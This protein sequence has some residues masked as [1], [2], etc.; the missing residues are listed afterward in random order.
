MASSSFW[1]SIPGFA[2][3]IAVGA[4]GSVF[5]VSQKGSIQR[6]TGAG[7]AKI[8]DVQAT[9]I[10]VGPRGELHFIDPGRGLYRFNFA[11]IDSKDPSGNGPQLLATDHT[12]VPLSVPGGAL[13]VGIGPAGTVFVVASDGA[14][15]RME[16]GAAVRLPGQASRIAVGPGEQPFVLGTDRRVYAW[17]NGAFSP[18]LDMVAPAVDLGVGATGVVW[19]AGADGRADCWDPTAGARITSL[20]LSAAAFGVGSDGLA[21]ALQQDGSICR[22]VS[23]AVSAALRETI[24][25]SYI[26]SLPQEGCDIAV[27]PEGN[28]WMVGTDSRPYELRGNDWT[29]VSGS[30]AQ[31]ITV[32]L[33]NQPYKVAGDLVW[34]REGDFWKSM[35][36]P[37]SGALDVAAGPNGSLYCAGNDRNIYRWDGSQWISVAGIQG[38]RIALGPLDVPYVLANDGRIYKLAGG[39]RILVGNQSVSARDVAVGI[40]GTIWMAGHDNN[41]YRYDPATK[42]YLLGPVQATSVAVAPNGWLL[43]VKPDNGLARQAASAILC[44]SRDFI[45]S[46]WLR[47]LGVEPDERSITDHQNH[48]LYRLQTRAQK[49]TEFFKCD[50]S[51]RRCGADGRNFV[52]S[53]CYR[54]LGRAPDGPGLDFHARRLAT[55]AVTRA[56]LDEE[57]R[58]CPEAQRAGVVSDRYFVIALGWRYLGRQMDEAGLSYH[59]NRLAIPPLTRRQLELE[60]QSCPEAQRYAEPLARDFVRSLCARYIAR[61]V[62]EA[63]VTFH[64]NRL[65]SGQTT[66]EAL[67]AEFKKSPEGQAYL[68]AQ[69][70]LQILCAAFTGMPAGQ[71]DV[72]T[73]VGSWVRED[74]LWSWWRPSDLSP[75]ASDDARHMLVIVYRYGQG[76]SRTVTFPVGTYAVITPRADE[77][78]Q[79]DPKLQPVPR[80]QMPTVLTILGASYGRSDVTL[81]ARDK[82]RGNLLVEDVNDKEWGST[83]PIGSVGNLVVVYQ[84]GDSPPVAQF[85]TNG[86][87]VS[88]GAPPLSILGAAFGNC[89]VTACVAAPVRNGILEIV[90]D[91]QLTKPNVVS[92]PGAALLVVYRYGSGPIQRR[93]AAY[94]SRLRISPDQHRAA[95]F[96]PLPSRPQPG[97]FILGAAYGL[98][99]VTERARQ[100]GAG[101]S[102]S[103]NADDATWVGNE[104]GVYGWLVVIYQVDGGRALVRTA[105]PRSSVT[106]GAPVILGAAYGSLD[107]TDKVAA[108]VRSGSDSI[109]VPGLNPFPALFDNLFSPGT[110]D[111]YALGDPWRGAEKLLVVAYQYGDGV[112]RLIT[113]EGGRA[114][115]PKTGGNPFPVPPGNGPRILAATY[116]ERDVTLTARRL[117]AQ[118]DCEFLRSLY[119]RYFG[120]D[121]DHAFDFHLGRLQNGSKSREALEAEFATCPEAQSCGPVTDVNFITS[122]YFRHLGRAPDAPGRDFALAELAAGRATR[123]QYDQALYDSPEAQQHRAN[124]PRFFAD[125]ATWGPSNP[126]WHTLVIVYENPAESDMPQTLVFLPGEEV[127]LP[128]RRPR[129]EGYIEAE[130]RLV[131]DLKPVSTPSITVSAAGVVV[132]V[133]GSV[134][135]TGL[136]GSIPAVRKK[137]VLEVVLTPKLIS[138]A[139]LPGGTLL[140]VTSEDAVDIL[141]DQPGQTTRYSLKPSVPLSF[142]VPRSGRCRF[143]IEATDGQ[144]LYP[145]LRARFSGLQVGCYAVIVPDRVLHEQLA[146]LDGAELVDPSPEKVSPVLDG[147]RALAEVRAQQLKSTLVPVMA[148]LADFELE[149]VES[150]GAV[151]RPQP[152]DLTGIKV[153]KNSTAFLPLHVSVGAATKPLRRVLRT[154]AA[155][156]GHTRRNLSKAPAADGPVSFGIF[157]WISDAFDKV[158]SG[159][160]SVGRA[161]ASGF[162]VVIGGIEVALNFTL[163]GMQS[164]ARVMERSAVVLAS[165]TED[166]YKKS[167]CLLIDVSS[168]LVAYSLQIVDGAVKVFKTAIT[169]A[170][171]AARLAFEFV[172]RL[173]MQVKQFIEFLLLFLNWGDVLETQRYLARAV[174]EELDRLPPLLNSAAADL[175]PL[176]DRAIALLPASSSTTSGGSGR[177][178]SSLPF[179]GDAWSFLCDRLESFTS[180]LSLGG[181]SPVLVAQA[182][183]STE[184]AV[185]LSA[186]SSAVVTLP[187]LDPKDLFT[188]P[189]SLLGAVAAPA[190]IVL[191]Q[192][193][194]KLAAFLKLGAAAASALRDALNTR[195]YVPVLTELIETFILGGENLTVLSLITLLAGAAYTFQYKLLK[196]SATG[197]TRG[198]APP[199]PSV[200]LSFA[201]DQVSLLSLPNE[202]VLGLCYTQAATQFIAALLG[203]LGKPLSVFASLL[204]I[205]VCMACLPSFGSFWPSEALTNLADLCG[206]LI[207]LIAGKTTEGRVACAALGTSVSATAIVTYGGMVSGNREP[208]EMSGLRLS[209]QLS[210]GV[211]AVVGGVEEI[212]LY[213]AASNL[214]LCFDSVARS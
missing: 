52:T 169:A 55:A 176:C 170:V 74:Q 17:I 63:G 8:S 107:V 165:F 135:P 130:L 167:K 44:S 208:L 92:Q 155:L 51:Q 123:A 47:Y 158:K 38:W 127:T 39:V 212:Q 125:D 134:A 147:D 30:N 159:L 28:I 76:P 79:F 35:L 7:F 195:L 106:I 120:H 15:Y 98:R 166:T 10:A 119:W 59:A 42:S 105:V 140:E 152:C 190:R 97:L 5:V 196:L 209:M 184:R 104:A 145:I 65:S 24:R 13:D 177:S 69:P 180:S 41:A 168:G 87:R 26:E 29:S 142:M 198:A 164:F 183:S 48:L 132:P 193:R 173:A 151:R 53:L 192:L 121:V 115:L 2:L 96:V 31:R 54:Y 185:L 12:L 89:D 202:A 1:Q 4:D 68:R 194:I 101:D 211:N 139:A 18:Y 50:G 150:Y 91:D 162:R 128:P 179:L 102:F 199:V 56:E 175:Q 189:T 146:R 110:N 23:V 73:L 100:L 197:P 75:E 124:P 99:D 82:V 118:R 116:G 136:A 154:G 214:G 64:T 126:R 33:N 40:D 149:T 62:D 67:E 16:S 88:I 58:T 34:N 210:S 207:D 163:E 46:L 86:S 66:R 6:W 201:P 60:F 143:C 21:W 129:S 186:F 90:V 141:T 171:D 77:R 109:P 84:I 137:S 148:Q 178:G 133:G 112:P 117:S 81:R 9:R 122:L 205:P 72:T 161:M 3:D 94:G 108:L 70:R 85:C 153:A 103:A 19:V 114:S 27:S 113:A 204:G 174:N 203:D 111:L 206:S 11:A 157:D 80:T 20:E 83:G 14:I 138:G 188:N 78:L 37:P 181:F 32:G 95:D 187:T 200:A 71:E 61:T 156:L 93:L 160:E 49:E 144:L 213:S 191:E 43:V 182:L 57:F 22:Q 172:T 25:W 45:R 36:Q 131:A